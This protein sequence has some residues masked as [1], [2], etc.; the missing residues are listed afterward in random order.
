MCP[1]HF[2]TTPLLPN[3][4]QKDALNG[5]YSLGNCLLICNNFPYS[6]IHL[7]IDVPQHT[8]KHGK[9]GS[10]VILLETTLLVALY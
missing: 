10:L 7:Q 6:F 8:P 9:I 5:I 1:Y 2:I 4:P 3:H